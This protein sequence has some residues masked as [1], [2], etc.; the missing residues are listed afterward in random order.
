VA[1]SCAVTYFDIPLLPGRA[2]F[3][4]ALLWVY[5]KPFH[6]S[7]RHIDKVGGLDNYILNIPREKQQSDLADE[8]RQKIEAALQRPLR[9]ALRGNTEAS[10]L[11]LEQCP[12]CRDAFPVH[13]CPKLHS[14]QTANRKD[15][16]WHAL[17]LAK[18]A[19]LVLWC[20]CGKPLLF[21]SSC[22]AV[23]LPES[24]SCIHTTWHVCPGNKLWAVQLAPARAQL[25][26]LHERGL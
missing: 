24:I 14:L 6:C 26:Q 11:Y 17:M 22:R 9:N 5:L 2:H 1:W 10:H 15:F 7:C 8:L 12:A 3:Q 20:L 4:W 25:R 23:Q 16:S 13:F 19:Y 18:Q 21:S